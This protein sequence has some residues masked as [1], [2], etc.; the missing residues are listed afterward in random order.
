MGKKY[1]FMVYT[2][3]HF[4]GFFKLYAHIFQGY[5]VSTLQGRHLSKMSMSKD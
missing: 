1:T 3:S 2:L 5:D 4:H